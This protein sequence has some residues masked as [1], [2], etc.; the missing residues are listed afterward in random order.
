M[1][2]KG[3]MLALAFAVDTLARVLRHGGV[4]AEAGAI[5]V[6]AACPTPMPGREAGSVG[7]AVGQVV[8]GPVAAVKVEQV[9]PFTLDEADVRI[10][11]V[12]G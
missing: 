4:V 8:M 9:A 12:L 1:K 2:A 11:G 10:G 6:R 3:V 5:K 7:L